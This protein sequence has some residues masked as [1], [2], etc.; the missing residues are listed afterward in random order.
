MLR[1]G[2]EAYFKWMASL[3]CCFLSSAGRQPQ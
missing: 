1:K 3:R 2:K